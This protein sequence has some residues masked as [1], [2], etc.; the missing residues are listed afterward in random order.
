[1]PGGETCG[2]AA[3]PAY[4]QLNALY[5]ELITKYVQFNSGS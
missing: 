2:G 5:S 4:L 1:M 3:S